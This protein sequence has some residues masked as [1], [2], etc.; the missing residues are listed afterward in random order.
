MREL[1]VVADDFTGACEMG[2]LFA[3]A[4]AP[5]HVWLDHDAYGPAEPV[6]VIDTDTRNVSGEAASARIRALERVWSTVAPSR[7]YKKI[8]STLRGPIGY[9]V[10]ALRQATRASH[11]LIAPALPA[12][13]RTT[14]AGHQLVRG[15]PIEYTPAAN[16]PVSAA[17]TS[18]L[19]TL[20]HEHVGVTPG[21]VGCRTVDGGPEALA[22]AVRQVFAQHP[23]CVVDAA[24]EQHL[25]IIA[26]ASQAL[27]ENLV[28][29]GTAGLAQH[30]AA[31]LLPGERPA[32]QPRTTPV[33]NTAGLLVLC[34]SMNPVNQQQLLHLRGATEA[35]MLSIIITDDLDADTELLTHNLETRGIILQAPDRHQPGKDYAALIAR[36]VKQ[37]LAKVRPRGIFATGGETARHTLQALSA[38]S[39]RVHGEVTPGVPIG[40]IQ[41]G[42]ADGVPLITKAGGFGDEDTLLLAAH[43][44][45]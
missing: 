35:S 15:V 32:P 20:F 1:I 34:G 14:I 45:P 39:V 10:E 44:F 42:S 3:R 4:H 16:D 21:R 18:H 43:Y 5:V 11:V 22:R 17:T 12:Q 8:D 19:P 40:I 7:L 23:Y 38:K 13:G 28:I 25:Q 36:T 2:A 24:T 33:S 41:G 29:V 6:T 37:L 27:T 30:L 26:R 9:E 31:V